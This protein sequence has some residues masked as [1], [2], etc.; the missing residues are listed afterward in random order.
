[1]V[2]SAFA[3]DVMVIDGDGLRLGGERVRLWA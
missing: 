1:M 3:A 2:T